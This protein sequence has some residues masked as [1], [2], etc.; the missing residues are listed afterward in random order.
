MNEFAL[1]TLLACSFISF[2]MGIHY[3]QTKKTEYYIDNIN[4]TLTWLK[5]EIDKD[6]FD[7]LLKKLES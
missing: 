3:E 5:E 4:N 6:I 2:I 1:L 7:K